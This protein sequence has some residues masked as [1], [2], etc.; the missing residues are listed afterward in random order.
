M[1]ALR[2]ERV[3]KSLGLRGSVFH[4]LARCSCLQETGSNSRRSSGKG[5]N[6]ESTASAEEKQSSFVNPVRTLKPRRPQTCCA[7]CFEHPWL[8][9]YVKKN[10][11][12]KG[13]CEAC[14]RHGQ[15]L[16]D[17]GTL[18]SSFENMLSFYELADDMA[19]D[20]VW[21]VQEDWEVFADRLVDSGRAWPLLEAIMDTGWDDDSGEP[22]MREA[23]FYRRRISRSFHTTMAEAWEEF[24]ARVREDPQTEDPEFHEL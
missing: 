10:S 11:G 4:I 7:A 24:G 13:T 19:D 18:Y 2:S 6:A 8:R 20:L 15:Q 5:A 1:G 22:P 17:V 21:Q 23:N 3:R 12:K 16:V 9:S 14:G